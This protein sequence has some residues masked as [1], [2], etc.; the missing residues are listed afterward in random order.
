[1]LSAPVS[2]CLLLPLTVASCCKFGYKTNTN[3]IIRT[4]AG[5][6]LCRAAVAA[7]AARLSLHLRSNCHSNCNCNGNN[8]FDS[9]YDDIC[10]GAGAFVA[11][12]LQLPEITLLVVIMF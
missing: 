3:D 8:Q 6:Q 12:Q 1:M 2:F 4:K 11:L 7:V 10:A 5:R 9:N